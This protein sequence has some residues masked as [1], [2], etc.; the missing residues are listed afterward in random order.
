[1]YSLREIAG[2]S[3]A[4]MLLAA[5]VVGY[6]SMNYRHRR[7]V[8]NGA[9]AAA[10]R[11]IAVNQIGSGLTGAVRDVLPGFVS[12]A[13]LANTTRRDQAR[14][15]SSQ[16]TGEVDDDSDSRPR[17]LSMSDVLDMSIRGISDAIIIEKIRT[18]GGIFDISPQAIIYLKRFSVSD[19][20]IQA[21][22]EQTG[23]C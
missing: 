9:G 14:G 11:S 12:H 5:T 16:R 20:V 13:L 1:M 17:M 22:Q 3:A 15:E 6:S 18:R 8:L 10:L 7:A 4:G 2:C 23:H 19:A 21:M